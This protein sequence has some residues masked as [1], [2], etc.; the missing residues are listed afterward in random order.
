MDL[1]KGP[2]L[3]LVQLSQ[4]I[5]TSIA[6]IPREAILGPQLITDI[7]PEFW[8]RPVK[9]SIMLMMKTLKKLSV[10]I[11]S[12]PQSSVTALSALEESAK[13]PLPIL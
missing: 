13:A 11:K 4:D 10:V 6:T 9:R 8:A 2:L 3:H 1:T 5:H 7:I 12:T